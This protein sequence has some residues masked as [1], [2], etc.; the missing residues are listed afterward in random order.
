MQIAKNDIIKELRAH[1]QYFSLEYGLKRIGLFGSYAAN[2]QNE[3]SDIDI[4]A[5]FEKPIG[6]KFIEFAEFLEDLLGKK[7]DILTSDGIKDIRNP[8]IAQRIMETV[9]YV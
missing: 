1:R 2:T 8:E 3:D 4:V 7:T 6:L 5:E 9:I